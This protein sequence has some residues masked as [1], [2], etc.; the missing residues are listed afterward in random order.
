M[1]RRIP[2]VDTLVTQLQKNIPV[3]FESFEL[4]LIKLYTP[5]YGKDFVMNRPT[6]WSDVKQQSNLSKNRK[7]YPNVNVVRFDQ[8]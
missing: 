2:F 8:E 4:N 5:K 1:N 3:S 7:E 6:F